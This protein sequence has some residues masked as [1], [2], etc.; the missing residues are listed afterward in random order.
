[1][2]A[3]CQTCHHH[4]ERTWVYAEGRFHDGPTAY[5]ARIP[6]AP[7]RATRAEAMADACAAM[8]GSV[9]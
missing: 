2:N 4:H 5:R 1:M 7:L 9:A 8:S 6:D 3:L